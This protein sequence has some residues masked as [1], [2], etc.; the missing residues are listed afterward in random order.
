MRISC[1]VRTPRSPLRTLVRAFLCGYLGSV[2]GG[3]AVDAAPVRG[4]ERI[5]QQLSQ[6]LETSNALARETA[7]YDAFFRRD[8][9]RA[10]VDAQGQ[11]VTSTGLR[12]GYVVQGIIWSE[13]RPL[14][15]LDDE[16]LREGD[17]IGPYFILQIQSV[18]LVV[19]RGT[20]VFFV[21]LDR[22]VDRP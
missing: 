3:G 20:D 19:Q 14:A 8:P 2:A 1:A 17:M 4:Y 18:G 5:A 7:P 9:M 12:S 6:A 10:L 22:G 21:P 15:V 16:L 11:L 13:D